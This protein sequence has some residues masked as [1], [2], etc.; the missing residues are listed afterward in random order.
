M[1]KVLF[2]TAIRVGSI[3]AHKCNIRVGLVEA[4][5]TEILITQVEKIFRGLN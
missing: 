1:R 2:D 5:K 4:T 3:L